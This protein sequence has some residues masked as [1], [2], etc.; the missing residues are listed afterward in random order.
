MEVLVAH[1]DGDGVPVFKPASTMVGTDKTGRLGKAMAVVKGGK[2]G[3][4]LVMASPLASLPSEGRQ[5]EMVGKVLV[6]EVR[7]D[8]VWG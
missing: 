7:V 1:Q 8:E 4:E 5:G 2:V 6:Q 3:V